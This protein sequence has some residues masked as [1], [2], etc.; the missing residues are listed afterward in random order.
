MWQA[1]LHIHLNCI[2]LSFVNWH[3]IHFYEYTFRYEVHNFHC[4]YIIYY[5]CSQCLHFHSWHGL[6]T[7][8]VSDFFQDFPLQPTD[9]LSINF[10]TMHRLN[11]QLLLALSLQLSLHSITL[12]FFSLW[13]HPF[14]TLKLK[15]QI[16]S[17]LPL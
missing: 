8:G 17:A 13:L 11:L 1:Y 10:P 14:L 7:W 15:S 5:S 2:H 9:T 4:S 16:G 12:K 3:F 6:C